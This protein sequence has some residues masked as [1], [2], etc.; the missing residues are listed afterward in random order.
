MV[1]E[2]CY[3]QYEES[4]DRVCQVPGLRVRPS[5]SYYKYL[6]SQRCS[7]RMYCID[8][9]FIVFKGKLM[10]AERDLLLYSAIASYGKVVAISARLRTSSFVRNISRS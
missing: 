4:D 8:K 3:G 1:T 6:V 10:I 2:S 7:K 9:Y 5:H